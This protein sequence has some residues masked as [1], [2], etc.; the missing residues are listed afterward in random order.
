MLPA[1]GESG[2]KLHAKIVLIV[3]ERAVRF[4]VASANLTENGYREN[5]EVVLPFIVSGEVPG[6]A[7]LVLE[8]VEAMPTVLA[9]WWTD[10]AEIVRMLAL[11][12]LREWASGLASDAKF[13]WG[14][15]RKR[16]WEQV[17]DSWPEGDQVERISIVSPFWSEETSSG[18]F[19]TFIGELRKRRALAKKAVV[20]LYTEAEPATQDAFR[21][22]LPPLGP[23]DPKALDVR[24]IARAVQP[25]PTDEPNTAD[26]LK[27]R[28]LHAKVLLLQGLKTTLAYVGSA[29]FT[30][31][32]WG[33]TTRAA[34]ANVE[35]GVVLVR[36]GAELVKA[37]LPP[38]TGKPIELDGMNTVGIPLE[39]EQEGA[40]PTFVHGVWLEPDPANEELIRLAIHI[41]HDRVEGDFQVSSAGEQAVVL[42]RGDQRSP[43]VT[44]VV[45][46][47]D[48][49]A[50]LL[51]EQQVSIWW[52][53]TN[54]P[55]DY[56]V[57]VRLSARAS[58]PT[59]PGNP[60]PR[61]HLLLAY[62]QGRISF[63]DLFPPPPGWEDD[64][65]QARM[66]PPQQ[67]EVDTSR[68]QS[69]QVRE[70]VEALQGIR[71]DLTAASKTTRASMRLAVS[72]PV[73]P[74]ALAKEV[75]DAART[76]RR[77]ATAAGFQLVEIATCL[78]EASRSKDVEPV[79][80]ALLDEGRQAVET[81]LAKLAAASPAELGPR[82]SFAR[83]A[84]GVLGWR[85][86]GRQP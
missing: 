26:V 14:G 80:R 2:Q 52:W 32:G 46:D 40:V 22:K 1:V 37:L 27:V 67:S 43:E 54:A 64:P 73:S 50:R 69:Y 76:G 72:G 20:D 44:H 36:R 25:R 56:P 61:E 35:A 29:N 7:P 9:P 3:H 23:I 42:M 30:A 34:S 77:S 71:D 24:L 5:R 66:A 65:E 81:M 68:I 58:L 19:T 12:K 6:A 4:Q 62:Y 53:E 31:P 13:V 51:R 18:P 10:S 78:K 57:N 85:P 39:K 70:F 28:T 84:Q 86:N 74:V 21:P 83:Y 49:V 33:F 59:V 60:N 79:W 17:L 45:L 63:T 8:A 16:L 47:V 75:R 15:T 48:G 55:C 41:D 82:T 38:T 11:G